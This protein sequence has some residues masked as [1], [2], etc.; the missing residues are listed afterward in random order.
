MPGRHTKRSKVSRR[1]R[2]SR[3][4][5]RSQKAR[6]FDLK[7]QRGGLGSIH[8]MATVDIQADPY[9]A[10]MLVGAEEAE[11]ILAARE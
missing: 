11:N 1:R 6:L 2:L 7:R 3:Y 5:R 8:P 10:R 9:S 4:R